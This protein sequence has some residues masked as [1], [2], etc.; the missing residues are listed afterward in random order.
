MDYILDARNNR[1]GKRVDGVLKQSFVYSDKGQIIGEVNNELS[2]V[3]VFV[4][5]EMEH[6]PEMMK[7]GFD[8]YRMIRDHLGSIR[9]V[10][11]IQ[12]G[13][14]MQE[15]EYDTFGRVLRDTNPGF[16]PFGFAGGLYDRDTGLVRFG[17]RDYDPEVGRWT[18]KDPILFNGGDTNLFGY[19][20]ND[21]VN[22]VDPEGMT[23]KNPGQVLESD[24]FAGGGG[25]P[26]A[27]AP[28]GRISFPV[29][30]Q[31]GSNCPGS[32]GGR[33]YSGHALDRMQG[34]GITPSS[35]ENTIKTGT[36][37]V[38]PN[39]NIQYHD[40]GNN[41]TVIINQNGGVVTVRPGPPK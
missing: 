37:N 1:M 40:A 15:M 26:P 25:G 22:W 19:V 18:S 13:A 24:P 35:V 39:G 31:K 34:R 16:Q 4:Y 32:I 12:T 29:E 3:R 6:S 11:N 2:E 5:G 17:A 14:I 41:I 8:H 9:M 33:S 30:V 28:M 36:S 27:S 21:P 38:Q 10:V 20:E 7:I 23:K